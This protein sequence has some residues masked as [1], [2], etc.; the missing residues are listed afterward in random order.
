ML[1]RLLSC[2]TRL[3]TQLS[4][5]IV[6]LG[7]KGLQLFCQGFEKFLRIPGDPGLIHSKQHGSL[8]GRVN[9][10]QPITNFFALKKRDP[11]IQPAHEFI[12]DL[13]LVLLRKNSSRQD[14]Q[15]FVI[16]FIGQKKPIELLPD[17]PRI[18]LTLQDFVE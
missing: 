10:M 15:G 2:V 1:S 4:P 7:R 8:A 3:N 18:I 5:V 14:L 12:R 13:L 16:A 11:S 6:S 9:L 17:T